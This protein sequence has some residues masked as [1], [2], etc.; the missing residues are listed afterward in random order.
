MIKHIR[1]FIT[2]SLCIISSSQ[3]LAA[4][5]GPL[6]TEFIP[7]YNVLPEEI[8]PLIR[9]FLAEE[10]VLIGS[11]SQLIVKTSKERLSEVLNVIKRFD[12][13]AHRLLISVIQGK[14]LSSANLSASGSIRG[15]IGL[16]DSSKTNLKLQGHLR[17]TKTKRG[18][19]EEQSIQT[20]DGKEAYI[21]VG[22][23]QP[24][25]EYQL[26]LHRN[27]MGVGESTQ[28]HNITRGFVVRPKLIGSRVRLE[29]SPWSDSLS[30]L[31]NGVIDTSRA[32]TTVT[33]A[34]G[35]W[36]E[37]GGVSEQS[38]E[39]REGTLSHYRSSRKGENRIFIRVE[40]LD[41]RSP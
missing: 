9:P 12:Q 39:H 4:E 37:L 1:L 23:Q 11:G 24:R 33:V 8:I 30:R 34:L 21:Q 5:G 35:E 32:Q 28:Y 6:K 3:S 26:Y 40:D 14:N 31:G 7:L 25:S 16:G 41:Q 19:A 36:I 29:I 22:V 38:S 10:D 18:D 2:I 27:S 17:Q 15:H 13:A 20:I